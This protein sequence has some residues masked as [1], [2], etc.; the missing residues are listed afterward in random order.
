MFVCDLM[1]DA[2]YLYYCAC[3][4][5]KLCR[6]CEIGSCTSIDIVQRQYIIVVAI[7]V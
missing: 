5:L 6:Y 3:L 1:L 4:R 7:V 2:M